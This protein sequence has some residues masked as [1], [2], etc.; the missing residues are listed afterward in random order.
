MLATTLTKLNLVKLS[1][2]HSRAFSIYNTRVKHSSLNLGGFDQGGGGNRYHDS[3]LIL[4]LPTKL[5]RVLT[6][7]T[8][9]HFMFSV[10]FRKSLINKVCSMFSLYTHR[11]Y[12]VKLGFTWLGLGSFSQWK[13]KPLSLSSKSENREHC[14]KNK[15]YNNNNKNIYIYI[16]RTY[17]FF[18]FSFPMFSVSFRKVNQVEHREHQ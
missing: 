16:T 10:Y 2:I 12:W 8:M 6:L 1:P 18:S 11:G 17:L 15:H 9:F 4:T 7:F 5:T 13:T 3:S 14:I